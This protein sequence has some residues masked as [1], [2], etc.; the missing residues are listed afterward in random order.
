ML[1]AETS[2]SP[3]GGAS[4]EGLDV[5]ELVD[6]VEAAGVDLAV[7]QGIEHE[8]VVRVGAVPHA[9]VRPAVSVLGMIFGLSSWFG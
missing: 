6:E 7:R 5:L 4:V 1:T 8:G 2:S 9:M 3:R